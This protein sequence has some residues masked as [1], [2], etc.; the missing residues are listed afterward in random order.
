VAEKVT[1][2]P[3]GQLKEEVSRVLARA[4][5][6]L[7]WDVVLGDPVQMETLAL[8]TEVLDEGRPLSS[9]EYLRQFATQLG[10][11]LRTVQLS[12]SLEK[13][14]TAVEEER[15]RTRSAIEIRKIKADEVR[16]TRA[17]EELAEHHRSLLRGIERIRGLHDTL[18]NGGQQAVM[19]GAGGI[20]SFA[21]LDQEMRHVINTLTQVEDYV[22]ASR[23]RVAGSYTAVAGEGAGDV[24]A[25]SP[26]TI[27]ENARGSSFLAEVI[28]VADNLQAATADR[29]H[30]LSAVLRLSAELLDGRH[31]GDETVERHADQVRKQIQAMRTAIPRQQFDL[32]NLLHDSQAFMAR[33]SRG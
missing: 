11:E 29:D 13:D 14:D 25:I 30:L 28:R 4:V 22:A 8:A 12:R 27:S 19:Q 16:Q 5:S 21:A 33:L 18:A 6:R 1:N 15:K 3:L 24:R 23:L 17:E 7:K 10:F 32:L 26:G 2:D 31:P 9:V 20:H